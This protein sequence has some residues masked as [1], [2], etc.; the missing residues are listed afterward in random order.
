MNQNNNIYS[1]VQIYIL[2]NFTI[3]QKFSQLRG[4]IK[5]KKTYCKITK[6]KTAKKNHKKLKKKIVQ[7]FQ[8]LSEAFV[9]YYTKMKAIRIRLNINNCFVNPCYIVIYISFIICYTKILK[10]ENK[11]MYDLKS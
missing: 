1:M 7:L 10:L 11:Y 8:S 9:Y 5:K 3:F 2:K 6:S 4:N